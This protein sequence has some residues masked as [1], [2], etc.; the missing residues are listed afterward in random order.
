[1]TVPPLLLLL[2][3]SSPFEQ[4]VSVTV[5]ATSAST[6]AIRFGFTSSSL[7]VAGRRP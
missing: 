6:A 5:M 1:M 3:E 2:P 4:A 7:S